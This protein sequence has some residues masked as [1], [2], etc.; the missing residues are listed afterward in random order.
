VSSD[1]TLHLVVN[2]VAGNGR[3]G[4]RWRDFAGELRRHGFGIEAHL[5]TGPGHATE[6][7]A[8]LAGEQV[9]TVVCVGGDGTVNEVVNGLIRD[10]QPVSQVTRLAVIP[11][12]TG[13]DLS[14]AL[15]TRDVKQTAMALRGGTTATMD[16]GKVQFVENRTGHL[17]TRYFVNVADAGIGAATAQRINNTSKRFGGLISYMSGAVR[18]IAAFEPWLVE[19]EVDGTPVYSGDAGMVVLANGRF[20]AG[21]MLVAPAAS[22]CDGMLDVFVLEGVSRRV[23][24]T[25]LLP[26]VYRG[27]HVGQAGVRHLLGSSVAVRSETSMLLELDGEQTGSVPISAGVARR[28]LRVVAQAEAPALEGCAGG[29]R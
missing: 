17:E 24:L 11:C 15:G 25:S 21:G 26:R 13:K 1:E 19:V 9:S 22:L 8:R 27:T 2:P 4:R 6:I 16:V 23:L 29:V 28:V 20:F 3:A 5:T 7:G 10:D 18:T 12:G 14:R